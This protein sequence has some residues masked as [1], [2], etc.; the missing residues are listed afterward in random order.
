[1]CLLSVGRITADLH[2][3]FA[4]NSGFDGNAKY[5]EVLQDLQRSE[6][7]FKFKYYWGIIKNCKSLEQWKAV[8]KRK[9]TSLATAGRTDGAPRKQMYTSQGTSMR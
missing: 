3:N 1:M 4:E 2:K 9:A 8:L 5:R 6:E 7:A